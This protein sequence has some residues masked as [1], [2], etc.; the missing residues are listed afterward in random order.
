MHT[1][2]FIGMFYMRIK[3]WHCSVR[4][5]QSDI[6][7]YLVLFRDPWGCIEVVHEGT[8]VYRCMV[9]V[10]RCVEDTLRRC[11]MVFWEGMLESVGE[12]VEDVLRCVEDTLRRCIMVYWEGSLESIGEVVEGVLRCVED[13]LRRCIMVYWEGMLEGMLMCTEEVVEGV[14]VRCARV[15]RS[16]V[17]VEEVHEGCMR[18]CAW[19][20]YWC[21]HRGV[22][23][24]C[25]RKVLRRCIRGL[26]RKSW[27][28][29]WGGARWMYW[30]GTC[31][32]YWGHEG[33]LRCM[34]W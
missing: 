24:R 21:G 32:V 8:F 2:L 30:E 34:R 25:T 3:R 6:S 18:G 13:T 1:K 31:R 15:L 4:A 16:W 9:G 11:I 27:G 12:V 29:Y 33:M 22:H 17:C 26:L 5:D 7:V 20:E 28:M 14:L 19:V 23:E 10:L